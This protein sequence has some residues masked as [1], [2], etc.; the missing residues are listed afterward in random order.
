MG[1]EIERSV[2]DNNNFVTVGFVDGKGS[3]TEINYYSFLDNP[4]VSGANQIYYRLKQVDFDGTFSYSD[5]IS[6]NL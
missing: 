6:V 5:V 3:S 4:Q 1:F 2:N